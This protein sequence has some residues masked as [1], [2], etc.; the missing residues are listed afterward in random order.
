MSLNN[1][2]KNKIRDLFGSLIFISV[3]YDYMSNDIM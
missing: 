1:S 2:S 3:R